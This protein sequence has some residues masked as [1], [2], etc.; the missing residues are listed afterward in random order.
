[1][2]LRSSGL[3]KGGAVGLMSNV[4]GKFPVW[5]SQIACGA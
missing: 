4:R 3:S 5:T 1:M 2:A